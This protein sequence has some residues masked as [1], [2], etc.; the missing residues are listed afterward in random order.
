MAAHPGLQ[1]MSLTKGV[2]ARACGQQIHSEFLCHPLHL[3]GETVQHKGDI[4]CPS[5]ELQIK[6]PAACAAPVTP[7]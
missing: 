7:A 4:L 1:A 2:T 6:S 5:E 3:A